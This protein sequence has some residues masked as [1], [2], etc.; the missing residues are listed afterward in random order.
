MG[1]V[2][3]G[4]YILAA[5]S[6]LLVAWRG[7]FP[8]E[9]AR[10]ERIFWTLAAV[11]LLFLAVNKQLDLQSALTAAARC[12]AQ[13]QGWYQDRRVVQIA[14]IIGLLVAGVMGLIFLAWLLRGTMR[15]TGL[16]LLGLCV[17]TVFVLVRA[18][19]FHHMDILINETVGGVRLNW[20]LELPGPLIVLLTAMRELMPSRSQ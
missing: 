8:A 11:L 10:R 1:W 16:A 7:R 15:R 20:V 18:A 4:V 19:G 2:T 9:T 14:F 12:L 3:V 5:A 6:A 17:V 13:A